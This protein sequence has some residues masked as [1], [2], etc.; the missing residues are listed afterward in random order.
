MKWAFGLFCRTTKIAIVYEIASKNHNE[1][2]SI[3]KAHCSPGTV[4]LSDQHSSYVLLRQSRSNLAKHGF[5]HFWVNHSNFYVH[6]KFQFV[7]TANIER[8]WAVLRRTQ[9][10]LKAQ[11]KSQRTAEYLS[12]YCLSNLIKKHKRFDWSLRMIRA[13]F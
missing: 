7:Y 12:T 4:L 9:P 1:L 11:R 13:Y 10:A 6:E 2:M 5:Y 3:I 8:T